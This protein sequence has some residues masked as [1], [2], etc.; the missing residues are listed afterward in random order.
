MAKA[1][2]KIERRHADASRSEQA[3]NVITDKHSSCMS[4]TYFCTFDGRVC[5]VSFCPIR[6][7][8]Q[9]VRHPV[10]HFGEGLRY[11]YVNLRQ[12]NVHLH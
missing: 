2:A 1:Y 4:G 10:S 5:L 7:G 9:V 8:V 11:I 6:L 12:C 3:A